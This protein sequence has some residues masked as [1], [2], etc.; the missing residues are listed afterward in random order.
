M[1]GQSY[2]LKGPAVLERMNMAK[3]PIIHS[4]IK[5]KSPD[6]R[7]KTRAILGPENLIFNRHFYFVTFLSASVLPGFSG[8]SLMAP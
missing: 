7:P 8:Y 2:Y 1:V 4:T 5:E 3:R 6:P